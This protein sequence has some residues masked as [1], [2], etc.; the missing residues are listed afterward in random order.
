MPERRRHA[1]Q[2]RPDP[3]TR[4]WLTPSEYAQ[5]RSRSYS[6]VARW[7]QQGSV[8]DRKGALVPV[9]GGDGRDYR[10]PLRALA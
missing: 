10:I 9:E 4:G 8:P 2:R 1:R 3:Q 7:C 6:T 5:A